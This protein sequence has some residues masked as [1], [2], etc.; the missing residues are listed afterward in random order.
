MNEN[1]KCA[2]EACVCMVMDDDKYCSEFCASAGD[3]DITEIKCDCGHP[4]C[5]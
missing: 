4:G 1:N 2:H 5:N 3:Q